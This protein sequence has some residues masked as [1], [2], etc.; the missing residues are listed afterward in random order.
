MSELDDQEREMDPLGASV[1]RLLREGSPHQTETDRQHAERLLREGSPHQ[2]PRQSTAL[3]P[4]PVINS[5]GETTGVSSELESVQGSQGTIAN[6]LVSRSQHSELE[7]V[8]GSHNNS[9]NSLLG[10]PVSQAKLAKTLEAAAR[11]R[12]SL[13]RVENLGLVSRSHHR[14]GTIANTVVSRSHHRQGTIANTPV[15][16]LDILEEHVSHPHPASKKSEVRTRVLFKLCPEDEIL[17][18]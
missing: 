9:N 10:T 7:S 15:D 5:S 12:D 3:N 4:Q 14:Q 17:K 16:P 2:T 18:S 13:H 6:M 1:A 11:L 8:Q